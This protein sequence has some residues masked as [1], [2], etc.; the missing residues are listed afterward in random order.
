[1]GGGNNN[2]LKTAALGNCKV[3]SNAVPICF[4]LLQTVGGNMDK[5]QQ[6]KKWI[7]YSNAI[8]KGTTSHIIKSY[9]KIKGKIITTQV[10]NKN[11]DYPSLTFIKTLQQKQMK[12]ILQSIWGQFIVCVCVSV[13]IH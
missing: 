4:L 2:N 3:V 8:N 9:I 13:F 6:N 1:M 12:P 7:S 10:T 5:I 11:L